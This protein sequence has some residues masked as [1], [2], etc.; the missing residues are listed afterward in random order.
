MTPGVVSV[1]IA[2]RDSAD[3]LPRTLDALAAQDTADP[4]EVIVVDD[5]SHDST[6]AVASAHPIGSRVIRCDDSVGAAAARNAGVP[7]ASGE[8][9]A[10]TDADCE[11]ASGWLSAGLAALRSADLVQG[12]VEPVREPVGPFDRTLWVTSEYGLY[13]AANLFVSKA[14]FHELG[15]FEDALRA[16]ARRRGWTRRVPSRPFGEDTWLGWRARRSGA[17]VVFS[18]AAIVRHAVFPGT[19][20]AYVLER[21]R[22]RLFPHLVRQIPELRDAFLWRRLFLHTRSA[23]T[24]LA[25]VSTFAAAARRKPLVLLGVLPYLWLLRGEMKRCDSRSSPWRVAAT[26]VAG[27]VVTTG[28]LLVG[29]VEARTLVL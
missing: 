11:P 19:E 23:A 28:A 8:F 27:D 21:T 3:T 24:D 13:E 9:L 6:A 10:F 18:D 20:M 22:R 12:R 5:A 4:F 17:R 25:L 15:G 14:L 2:A 26:V 29:S 16:D 7:H 1:V